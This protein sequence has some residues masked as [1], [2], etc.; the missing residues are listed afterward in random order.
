MYQS[1]I[2]TTEEFSFIYNATVN[3]MY[4]SAPRNMITQIMQI[5]STTLTSLFIDN[6][7]NLL[8]AGKNGAYQTETK[9]CSCRPP[10][11]TNKKRHKNIN[12][13]NPNQWG[14]FHVLFLVKTDRFSRN[15]RSGSF[16]YN[17]RTFGTHKSIY[18]NMYNRNINN[19]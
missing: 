7:S 4:L 9:P 1:I 2:V 18:I 17:Q 11:I 3:V 8:L 15:I 12:T 16:F 10:A 6:V 13:A 19:K 14:L 5:V